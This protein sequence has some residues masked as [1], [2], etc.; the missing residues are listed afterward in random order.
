MPRGRRPKG[1]NPEGSAVAI[2]SG[3]ELRHLDGLTPPHNRSRLE[4]SRR[5]RSQSSLRRDRFRPETRA[6][7]GEALV[8]G[9][10]LT[11]GFARA[12]SPTEAKHYGSRRQ[13]SRT[14]AA[15]ADLGHPTM[16]SYSATKHGAFM[17]PSGRNQWQAVENRPRK[18]S[19]RSGQNRCRGLRAVAVTQNGKE[20]VDGSSPSEGL[21][22]VPV[23]RVFLLPVR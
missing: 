13:P 7:S 8:V 15:P 4:R 12:A 2:R 18:K 17:E 9:Y 16:S 14:S 1:P 5:L 23:N 21:D 22:K 20:G 6:R 11:A 10:S 3:D 19:V